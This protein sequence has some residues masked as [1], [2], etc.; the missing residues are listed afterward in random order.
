MQHFQHI[1]SSIPTLVFN[2]VSCRNHIEIH[3]ILNMGIGIELVAS[4]IYHSSY[5]PPWC[6]GA[7]I[8]LQTGDML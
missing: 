5:F 8:E 7:G 3:Q 1:S 6:M 2:G 4:S